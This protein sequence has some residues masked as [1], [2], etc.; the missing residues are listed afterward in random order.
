MES[1]LPLDIKKYPDKIL[2]SKCQVVEEITENEIR[3]F[4]MMVYT[5]QYFGGIGLAAPQVGIPSRLIIAGVGNRIVKLANPQIIETKGRDKMAE[6]CLSIPNIRV[7]V[8]RPYEVVIEGINEKGKLTQ[9]KA[10]GLLA[11]VLQHEID[12]LNGKL[13]IDYMGIF[14]KLKLK[15][16]G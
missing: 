10:K 7:E 11:R 15:L 3:I 12:H 4:E 8:K 13:I 16:K 14:G 2:R 1:G 5:M 9:I 6:G